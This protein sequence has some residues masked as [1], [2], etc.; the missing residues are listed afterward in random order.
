MAGQVLLGDHRHFRDRPDRWA[1][2]FF[3]SLSSA[4]SA[5]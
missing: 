1:F 5:K 4:A 3:S 2:V